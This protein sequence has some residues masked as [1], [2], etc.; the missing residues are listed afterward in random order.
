[1]ARSRHDPDHGRRR[2]LDGARE[3]PARRLPALARDPAPRRRRPAA[4]LLRADGQRRCRVVRR[5]VRRGVR[6]PRRDQ[7]AAAVPSR[8]ARRAGEEIDLRAYVLAQDVI[9]VGGGSTANLL[10]VWRL[11]GLDEI[12]AEA[13]ERASSSA[14]IS[15][16]MNCWYESRSPTPSARSPGCRTGSASSPAAPART[17]TARPSGVRRTSTWSAPARSPGVRRGGRVRA[18]LPRRR[19]RRGGR[20][21]GPTHAPS[22]CTCPG[23]VSTCSTARRRRASPRA[24]S[25]CATSA[26]PG[27]HL[28]VPQVPGRHREC[29]QV[30]GRHAESAPKCP[31]GAWS[32]P[33]CPVGQAACCTCS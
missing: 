12:L 1:M 24:P 28:R 5:P 22:G 13:A 31:V 29:P 30:P 7:L 14:G 9:Y 4:G 33:Q 26:E 8:R 21:R 17:T 16:G 19:A 15:A 20:A 18:A 11:H 25:K 3:P 10:A 32:A 6:R 23:T 2:V 27:R